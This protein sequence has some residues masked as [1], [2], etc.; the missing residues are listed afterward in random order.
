MGRNEDMKTSHSMPAPPSVPQ[1]SSP[2][3]STEAIKATLEDTV[4]HPPRVTACRNPDIRGPAVGQAGRLGKSSPSGQLE[5]VDEKGG[6]NCR[7]HLPG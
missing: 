6:E 2:W 1:S 3:G 5:Q 4:A 7:S